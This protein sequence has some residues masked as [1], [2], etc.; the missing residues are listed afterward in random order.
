MPV[1]SSGTQIAV[2]PTEA[3]YT[4]E[5]V[6]PWTLLQVT[7]EGELALRAVLEAA[8]S[9]DETTAVPELIYAHLRQ[10]Q[11]DD[12]ATWGIMRLQQ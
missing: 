2:Q 7:P 1:S 8:E 6:I 10:Y 9:D 12:P 5:A 4:L 11:V 3:G